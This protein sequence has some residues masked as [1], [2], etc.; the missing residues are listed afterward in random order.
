VAKTKKGGV[1]GGKNTEKCKRDEASPS[2]IPYYRRR[3]CAFF[4][5]FD[6]D[7]DDDDDDEF[8]VLLISVFVLVCGIPVSVTFAAVVWAAF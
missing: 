7:D 1:G 5:S 6:F 8:L 2:C 4:M 3:R